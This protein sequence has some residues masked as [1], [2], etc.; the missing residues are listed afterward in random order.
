MSVGVRLALAFSTLG[1]LLISSVATLS[2]LLGAREV[3]SSIDSEL[4]ERAAIFEA[5]SQRELGLAIQQPDVGI[6]PASRAAFGTDETGVQ[7]LSSTGD[8][9]GPAGPAAFRV[10]APVVPVNEAQFETLSTDDRTIRILTVPLGE[11]LTLGQ[12]GDVAAIQIWR[13]ITADEASI[14]GLSLRLI[15]VSAVG[16]MLVALASWFAGRWLTRPLIQLSAAAEHLTDLDATPARIEIDRADEIGQLADSFNS[17]L[18]AL[19]VGREQ[20]QRL[21][22]DASHELRTPL[23][24]L[25]LRTEYLASLDDLTDNQLSIVNGAVVDVEQLATLVNDLVD[26]AAAIRTV[27]ESP[28]EAQLGDMLDGVVRRSSITSG[29]DIRIECDDNTYTVYPSMIQRAVQNL[30]DNAIKYSP[31][32]TPITISAL[33]G[34]IEVNDRGPGIPAEDLGHVFDRFFRSPKARSRPGNGIGLAIVKQVAE[35]HRGETWAHNNCEGG[36]SIGFSVVK[37]GQT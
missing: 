26:L 34:R 32:G 25:R 31:E 30:V 19:E 12:Q 36:A 6:P 1:L 9:I 27:D 8:P 10:S 29:R 3:R 5:I 37:S 24:S 13:D 20:Q 4:Q 28:Q 16:V 35:A 11:T 15:A 23:T 7:F 22:A 33:R 21:V 18:S 17:M 2:W 14:N